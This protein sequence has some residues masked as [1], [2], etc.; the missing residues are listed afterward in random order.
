M[1]LRSASTALCNQKATVGP[2]AC[3]CLDVLTEFWRLCPH[4]RAMDEA[5]NIE[6]PQRYNRFKGFAGSCFKNL[7]S[8]VMGPG[9]K[10]SHADIVEGL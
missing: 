2:P 5:S 6:R 9:K 4:E 10:L 1:R 7:H 8:A 3:C